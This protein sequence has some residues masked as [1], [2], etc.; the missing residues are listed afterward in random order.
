MP[1]PEKPSSE[2]AESTQ[3]ES[4]TEAKQQLI[5]DLLQQE[6]MYRRKLG[7]PLVEDYAV[8]SQ[9]EA[10]LA[11]EVDTRCID[12]PSKWQRVFEGV[13]Q[14]YDD[15]L[16]SLGEHD[17]GTLYHSLRVARNAM[18]LRWYSSSEK[19]HDPELEED[20]RILALAG[21]LHDMG[22]MTVPGELINAPRPLED[23]EQD[24]MNNHPVHSRDY[25][26]SVL[27][28]E[29]SQTREIVSLL[30][31]FHHR[32]QRRAY[33]SY[34]EEP[35]KM[36]DTDTYIRYERLHMIFEVADKFD[37]MFNKRA[38]NEGKTPEEIQAI[39]AED[40]KEHSL[41]DNYPM[42]ISSLYRAWQGENN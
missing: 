33:P 7:L 13:R 28:D 31:L 29:T 6:K 20:I 5:M 27:K 12:L 8:W 36:L 25:V 22:K 11:E 21:M 32:I 35:R 26:D 39:I 9:V 23:H 34:H 19:A 40:F 15:D 16:R 30:A 10:G 2:F 18:A 4:T 42:W 3:P 1:P 14:E 17:P 38:Y 41:S 24:V 37:A